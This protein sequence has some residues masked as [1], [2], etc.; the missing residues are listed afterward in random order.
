VNNNFVILRDS[1]KT[2]MHAQN[3]QK[4]LFVKVCA[5]K[6]LNILINVSAMET[7][8]CILKAHS[9]SMSGGSV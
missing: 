6:E 9:H 3:M 4:R 5:F 2:V 1:S 8:A 7:Y